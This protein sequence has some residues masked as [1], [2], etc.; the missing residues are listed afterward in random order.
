MELNH[1]IHR[2]ERHKPWNVN[3]FQPLK[4]GL[5]LLP[6]SCANFIQ[7]SVPVDTSKPSDE[8]EVEAD[9]ISSC[10]QNLYTKSNR[11]SSP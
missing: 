1:C 6:K 7:W 4:I 3:F 9:P 10:R 8:N 2:S 11:L 5:E